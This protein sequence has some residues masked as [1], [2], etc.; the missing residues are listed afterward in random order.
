MTEQLSDDAGRE[1]IADLEAEVARLNDALDAAHVRHGMATDWGARLQAKLAAGRERIAELEAEVEEWRR[2]AVEQT[3]LERDRA[4]AAEAKLAAVRTVV[5]TE[6]HW[7]EDCGWDVPAI[8]ILA[9]LD[10]GNET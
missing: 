7:N 3:R 10:E 4:E 5:E 6:K 1:R 8:R 2:V 9:V